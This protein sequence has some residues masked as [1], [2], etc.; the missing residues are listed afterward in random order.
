MNFDALFVQ[1]KNKNNSYR[2]IVGVDYCITIWVGTKNT[3]P[4]TIMPSLNDY[5][6]YEMNVYHVDPKTLEP[7]YPI[8]LV[9]IPTIAGQLIRHGRTD[10]G[11]HAHQVPKVIVE[12]IIAGL[13]S[14]CG[15]I[16]PVGYDT[17][18]SVANNISTKNVYPKGGKCYFCG[19]FDEFAGPSKKNGKPVCYK[20]CDTY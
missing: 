12:H 1:R 8:T 10:P 6:N 11:K 16:L 5:A 7:T 3:T 18:S 9:N 17:N 15:V 13:C 19:C 4:N 14:L 2:Y 20:H